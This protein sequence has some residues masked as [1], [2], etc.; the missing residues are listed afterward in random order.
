MKKKW[1]IILLFVVGIPL[2]IF[3]VVKLKQYKFK[4]ETYVQIDAIVVDYDEK[5]SDDSYTYA[6]VVEYYVK[7]IRYTAI[8]PSYSSFMPQMGRVMEIRYN[9]IAPEDVIFE[10]DNSHFLIIG[11]GAA[12]IVVGVM[13]IFKK[14]KEEESFV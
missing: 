3:G 2:L 14:P 1:W 9:P 5:Y 12:F 7:N 13:L 6:P 8:Y 4:H 11:C 10:K